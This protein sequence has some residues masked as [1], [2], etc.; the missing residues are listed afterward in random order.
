[1]ALVILTPPTAVPTYAVPSL[2]IY[3]SVQ[4]G[5]YVLLRLKP[6]VGLRV[7]GQEVIPNMV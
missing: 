3:F 4:L 6:C 7:I 1:M 5:A 2:S